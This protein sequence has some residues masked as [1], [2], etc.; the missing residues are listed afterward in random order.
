MTGIAAGNGRA[1]AG[2]LRG[3]ASQSELLIV[4]LGSSVGASFPRTTR[5]MEAI[6]YVVKK[7]V[8]LGKPVAINLS[9]GNNYGSHDGFSILETYIDAVSAYGKACIVVGSGNEGGLRRHTSGILEMN[10]PKNIEIAVSSGEQSLNIQIWKNF[11]DDFDIVLSSPGGQI[12]GPIQKVLGTQRFVLGNTGVYLYYGEPTPSN[13]AQEI[14]IELIPLGTF[15]DAGFWNIQLVPRNIVN[16]RYDMWLPSGGTISA[17]TGFLRPTEEVTLTIPSTAAKVITVGAYNAF[18]DSFSYFSG[19]GYTRYLNNIKPDLVAPGYN[20][21]STA[22]GGGY[23]SKTGTSMATPFVTGSAALMMEW[24]IV[25]GNDPYL[26]GEKV[27]AY[28]IAGTRK[29][30]VET[31][32]PNPTLGYGAL[33][34]RES[35]RWARRIF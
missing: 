23:T 15:I 20:I 7:A 18:L 4:K 33:C 11:F 21:T 31:E 1:S 2:R 19:R 32:Y 30:P 24:G 16:G 3:I 25:D 22:P 29:L 12:V 9:F 13:M 26:Y 14:Y 17:E 10:I 28:L 8:E 6:D 5:L 34:L 35:F 27:K